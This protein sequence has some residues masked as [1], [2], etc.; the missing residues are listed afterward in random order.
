MIEGNGD[1]SIVDFL[2]HICECFRSSNTF[3]EIIIT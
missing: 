1:L 3:F 2:I